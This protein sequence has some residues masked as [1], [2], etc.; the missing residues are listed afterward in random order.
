[1][2]TMDSSS[3]ML[4]R[5]GDRTHF[6]GR[7]GGKGGVGI[8]SERLLRDAQAKERTRTVQWF[9]TARAEL[10][11]C[12]LDFNVPSVA[13]VTSEGRCICQKRV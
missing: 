13:V 11:S 2:L 12:L 4:C 5:R 1:M 8:C 7:W 6:G 9:A 10:G 3:P